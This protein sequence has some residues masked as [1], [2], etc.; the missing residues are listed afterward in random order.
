MRVAVLCLGLGRNVA[1]LQ[2]LAWRPSIDQIELAVAEA[3]GVDVSQ[4][5]AKRIKNNDSRVAAVYLIRKLTQVS[6]TEL[7]QR[8]GGVSETA[9]SKTV[10]RA[11]IPRD[12]QRDWKQ[13]LSRLEKSLRTRK[14]SRR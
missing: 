7:A 11:E 5:S 3:F 4:L 13:K 6:A 12:Q 14:S 8:Y 9:I 2:H 10:Q 1:E